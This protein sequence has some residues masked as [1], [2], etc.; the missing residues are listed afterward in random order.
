MVADKIQ[1]VTRVLP[2]DDRGHAAAGLTDLILGDYAV[3]PPVGNVLAGIAQRSAILRQSDIIDVAYFRAA[4]ALAYPA[5]N[6]AR[7]SRNIIVEFRLD[8]FRREIR[9]IGKRWGENIR[10][11]RT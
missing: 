2:V 6:V 10:Q 9:R 3:Q 5:H 8:Y 4:D 7:Y 11:P 1:T